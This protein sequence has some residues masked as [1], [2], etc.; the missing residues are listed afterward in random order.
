MGNIFKEI[1]LWLKITLPDMPLSHVTH[2]SKIKSWMEKNTAI[3]CMFTK[4]NKCE[5]L[6]M[7]WWL[8]S[9]E[10]DSDLVSSTHVVA[11]NYF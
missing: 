9:L 1:E 8:R 3:F 7:A 11:H 2:Q 10:D 6:D 5:S 4:K